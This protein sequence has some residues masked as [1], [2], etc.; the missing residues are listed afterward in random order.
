MADAV[1]DCADEV[2]VYEL[3]PERIAQRPAGLTAL[4]SSSRLLHARR[5]QG[6]PVQIVDRF[7]ADLPELLR[8]GDLLVLNNSRVLPC[9]FF[10]E[11]L[12]SGSQVEVLM[13]KRE[14]SVSPTERLR[15]EAMC[16]PAKR[17]KAGDVLRLS[18]RFD[19]VVEGR[20]ADGRRVRLELNNTAAALDTLWREGT[21]PIPPYIRK[22]HADESDREF[23]QTV[24]A[25]TPGSVAAPTAGLHFTEELLGALRARGIEQRFITLHVGP[26]SFLSVESQELTSPAMMREAYCVPDE[27]RRAI[28]AARCAGRR[29]VA[30]G[31]TTV[32]ALESAARAEDFFSTQMRDD[33]SAETELLIKPRYDFR[34]VDAL[35]TNFHQ[36]GST[37]LLLVAAFIGQENIA[38]IYEHALAGE[39]RFLS[40]GD[41]M[42]LERSGGA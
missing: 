2:F 13:V 42:L 3:A 37:H 16:R 36:P 25:Q 28:A 23:Y 8:D 17:L 1:C 41:A 20:T 27:T 26:A 12:R 24:F 22:G 32:R 40:Y 35:I 10:A 34:V 15:F 31:T 5:E 14:N 30:V 18:E 6:A 7:F 21:M 9:R 33:F 11:V 19:A 29:I 39:Y 38:R 4:R